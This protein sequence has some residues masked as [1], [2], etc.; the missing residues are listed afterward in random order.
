MP[1]YYLDTSAIV[2]RYVDEQGTNVM[3]RLL[4][5]AGSDSRFYT[6]LLSTLEFTSVITRL[7]NGGQ[8]E[9][10]AAFIVLARFRQDLREIFRLWPLDASILRAALA[11]VERHAL[12]SAD[13]IHLA[14]AS[15]IF[16]LAPEL[17]GIL[18]SSDRELLSAAVS[19]GVGVL[20]PQNSG[21]R[22]G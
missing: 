7:A 12:R 4:D 13:A 3:D 18:V 19:S 11:V 2:K 14:T 1:I 6:S 16:S 5:N 9:R 17:D 22:S 15:S 8:L 21:L 10:E 20:D